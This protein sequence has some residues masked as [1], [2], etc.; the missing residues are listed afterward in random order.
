MRLHNF[1]Y[2]KASDRRRG[3]QHPVSFLPGSPHAL[4]QREIGHKE[5]RV[6][7]SRKRSG[8][9]ASETPGHGSACATSS[10]NHQNMVTVT[11]LDGR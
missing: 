6:S 4:R 3:P 9:P 11:H 10:R 8:L 2:R 5:V 7:R 1:L